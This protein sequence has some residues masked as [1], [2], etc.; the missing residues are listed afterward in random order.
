MGSEKQI[1]LKGDLLLTLAKLIKKHS[2]RN[3]ER[4]FGFSLRQV[5]ALNTYFE[6]LHKDICDYFYNITGYSLT[7]LLS[8]M[9]N[10]IDLDSQRQIFDSNDFILYKIK[11]FM[12]EHINLIRDI[13]K[14]SLDDKLIPES[15]DWN[16]FILFLADNGRSNSIIDKFIQDL[17]HFKYKQTKFVKN[18]SNIKKKTYLGSRKEYRLF[19]KM[20]RDK[21]KESCRYYRDY[22]SYDRRNKQV[23]MDELMELY[24]EET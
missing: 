13:Y 4:H 2:H 16:L 17:P 10:G 20:D 8:G 15:F 3:I 14:I 7:D 5:R 1:E 23:V 19:K 24:Y 12:P 22:D 21:S 11:F 6:S 9:P 18:R